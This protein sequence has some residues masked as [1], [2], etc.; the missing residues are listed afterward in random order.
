MVGGRGEALRANIGSKSLISLQRG[1]LTQNFRQK[2][3][4]PTNDSSQNQTIAGGVMTSYQ[5]QSPK[6]T[7]LFSASDCIR[8][9]RWKYICLPNFDEIS[10]STAEIKLL[11]LSEN[12]RPPFWISIS[13]FYFCLIF[14]IGVSFCIGLPHFVK[15]EQP[16]AEL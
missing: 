3:S 12:G 2:E 9:R 11:P 8:L 7:S 10:Q 1:R 14:V 5:P 16:L 13:G 6:A 15:I 4:P